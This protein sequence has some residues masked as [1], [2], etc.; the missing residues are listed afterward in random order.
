[1]EGHIVAGWL[2]HYQLKTPG[3]SGAG[4]AT[5][6][7]GQQGEPQPDSVLFIA[8]DLGGQL[9]FDSKG[10]FAGAPELVVEIARSSRSFD[11]GPKKD[12]YERAGVQEYLVVELDPDD[13]HWFIRR[14]ERFEDLTAG[15]DGIYRSEVFPGLWLDSAALFWR[16]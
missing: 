4:G 5:V 15:P 16:M 2:F 10:Y 14:G 12:D 1:M 8:P 7:L 9:D 13:V 11:L 6:I 3:V